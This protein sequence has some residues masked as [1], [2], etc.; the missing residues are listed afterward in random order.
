MAIS[1]QDLEFA[2][3]M[4][5][6]AIYL[7][8]PLNM[9]DTM[10]IRAF[11]SALEE[12]EERP[13]ENV[14][15]REWRAMVYR[16]LLD[17]PEALMQFTQAAMEKFTP[18]QI[19]MMLHPQVQ[20]AVLRRYESHTTSDDDVGLEEA[21]REIS[22]SELYDLLQETNHIIDIVDYFIEN[23]PDYVSR[24]LGMDE[25]LESAREAGWNDGYELGRSEGYEH[26]LE[27]ASD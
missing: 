19:S 20:Q 26:G 5:D 15:S 18:E 23:D 7:G 16:K 24:Q 22:S 12:H 13:S 25:E 3:Y 14:R 4:L 2:K 21:L 10:M 6:Q 27:A 1:K 17:D 11:I 8:T 9:Q